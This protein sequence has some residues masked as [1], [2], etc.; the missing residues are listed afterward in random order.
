MA[1]T[2][3]GKKAAVKRGTGTS[4]DTRRRNAELRELLQSR[5]KQLTGGMSAMIREVRSRSADEREAADSQDGTE[6]DIQDD[7]SLALIQMKSETL[8]RIDAALRRVDAGEYGVCA[9]CSQTIS[10]ERLRALPFAVRC[11]SCEGVREQRRAA[12]APSAKSA[13]PNAL[14]I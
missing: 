8:R 12:S 4:A 10:V 6:A 5:R 3:R 13:Y 2:A 7:L 11:T 9:E 1:K 14:D